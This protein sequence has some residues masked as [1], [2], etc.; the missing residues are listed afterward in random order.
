ME[1]ANLNLA[2]A[3]KMVCVTMLMSLSLIMSQK[4]LEH[5]KQ[6]CLFYLY[7]YTIQQLSIYF[8]KYTL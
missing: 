5:L 6:L 1:F 3:F 4:F 8:F 7:I 2:Q